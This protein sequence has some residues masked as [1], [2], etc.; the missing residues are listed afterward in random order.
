MYVCLWWK[1][2]YATTH[3]KDRN[4]PYIDE[5]VQRSSMFETH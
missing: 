5:I 1:F 4:W 2:I 3:A